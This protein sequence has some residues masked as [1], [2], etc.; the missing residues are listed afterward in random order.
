M[1]RSRDAAKFS[2]DWRYGSGG[3]G[4]IN[5]SSCNLQVA[6]TDVVSLYQLCTA[7]K[8]M[9]SLNLY[10]LQPPLAGLARQAGRDG[11]GVRGGGRCR[12]GARERG[13]LTGTNVQWAPGAVKEF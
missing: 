4:D 12:E 1:G 13:R 5:S 11:G 7:D 6:R 10:Q 9:I 3:C 8:F 2:P